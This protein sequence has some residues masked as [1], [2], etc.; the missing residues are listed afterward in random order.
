MA[1]V[2]ISALEREAGN[3]HS[4]PEEARSSGG[5]RAPEKRLIGSLELIKGRNFNDDKDR[6]NDNYYY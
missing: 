6:G 1:V 3:R 2:K 4:V 5:Y